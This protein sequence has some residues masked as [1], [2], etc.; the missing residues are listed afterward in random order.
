MAALSHLRRC[1]LPLLARRPLAQL[2]SAQRGSLVAAAGVAAAAAAAAA[3]A[4]TTAAAQ[5]QDEG[6]YVEVPP[7]FDAGHYPKGINDN[8]VNDRPTDECVADFQARFE[9]AETRD[10]ARAWPPLV[11]LL[12]DTIGLDG[13]TIADI[14]AGTGLFTA[15][16][17]EAVGDAGSVKSVEISPHFVK[18]LTA[19]STAEGTTKNVA[20]VQ[21]TDTETG[22]APN[23]VDVAFICDVYH[24]LAMPGTFMRSLRRA[25][26]PGGHVVL[27]DFHRDPSKFPATGRHSGG[28]VLVHVRAGQETFRAEVEEAGF[29]LVAE[30][31]IEGHLEEN[32]IMVF[33]RPQG[34]GDPM[35]KT[36]QQ[37]AGF[38]NASLITELERRLG[39]R[40]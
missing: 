40:D 38:D 27:I 28:W 15:P 18:H 33:K 7:V 25:I 2:C 3:A 12:Q 30:P 24:H 10:I 35:G 26:R 21:C 34:K 9:N 22:L 23:S 17:L 1:S 4:T 6:S 11:A 14:G 8:F 20:V 16:F 32:Y 5:A 29:E 39:T 37:L 19:K 31:V 36:A 13:R